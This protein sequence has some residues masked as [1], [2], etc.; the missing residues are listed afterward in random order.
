M[1]ATKRRRHGGAFTLIEALLVIGVIAILAGLILPA[2]QSSREAARRVQ[3]SSN[4]K[5]LILAVHGFEAAQGGFPG[6][7]FAR[8]IPP[9]SYINGS[10]FISILGYLDQGS[11][12]HGLNLEIPFGYAFDLPPA[13]TTVASH[14]IG[15]LVC[16]SDPNAR[17]APYACT[18]YRAC[19][20]LGEFRRAADGNPNHWQGNPT[21][22]GTFNPIPRPTRISEI[23]DGLAN[24]LAFSEKKVGSGTASF[25]PSR[26]WVDVKVLGTSDEY[27]EICSNLRNVQDPRTDSGRMW[28]LNGGIY[29]WFFASVSPNSP[30]PDCG[31]SS[32]NGRGVFAARSYHPGAVCAAMADG[33]VRL[34]AS[35]IGARTW[36]ALGTRSG[37]EVISLY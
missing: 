30:V 16:P 33:S 10:V 7:T 15:L 23:R 28:L 34:F 21:E 9:N 6:A 27:I 4:L 17:S 13:N 18:S 12:Y 20:G 1:R 19:V 5:Q 32:L 35:S 8:A 14:T 31:T 2:V 29:T 22:W 24:T 36:R 3:C 37:A 25:D 26:D 11:A